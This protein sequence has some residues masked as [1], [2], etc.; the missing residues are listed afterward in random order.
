MNHFDAAASD[1]TICCDSCIMRSSAHCADCVVTHVLAPAPHE[2]ISFTGEEMVAMTLL[3]RA[4]MVPT[5]LHR[6]ADGNHP[7]RS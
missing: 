4:G 1:I 6:E 7:A 3:A 2:R 5:L